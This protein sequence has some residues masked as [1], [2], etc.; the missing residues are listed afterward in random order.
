MRL[1]YVLVFLFWQQ[2][3]AQCGYDLPEY[4]LSPLLSRLLLILDGEVFAHES[5]GDFHYFNDLMLE[6]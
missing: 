5:R 4:A 3:E 1:A 2:C 6:D